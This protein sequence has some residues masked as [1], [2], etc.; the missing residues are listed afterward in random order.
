MNNRKYEVDVSSIPP[1]AMFCY[2]S[3]FLCIVCIFSPFSDSIVLI[4]DIIFRVSLHLVVDWSDVPATLESC[5]G[6]CPDSS[7]NATSIPSAWSTYPPT[8]LSITPSFI[9]IPSTSSVSSITPYSFT[10]IPPTSSVFVTCSSTSSATS[11]SAYF[12]HSSFN[13]LSSTSS[14]AASCSSTTSSAFITHPSHSCLSSPG[15][16]ARPT[17]LAYHRVSMNLLLTKPV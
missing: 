6:F 9:C 3:K 14:C 11:A 16:S 4:K 17:G 5:E 12:A 8:I 13:W 2:C 10:C 7:A 1:M 15:F